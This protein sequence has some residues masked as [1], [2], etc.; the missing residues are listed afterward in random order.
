VA[1][2]RSTLKLCVVG[3]GW[4]GLAAAV[5]AAVAGHAVTLFEMAPQLGGRARRVPTAPQDPAG[6]A[7]DNGQHILIGA[8][9]ESLRLMRQVGVDVQAAFDRRPLTLQFA[10]GTGLHLPAGPALTAFARG[11]LAARGWSLGDRL[12]LLAAAGSWLLRGFRC[13]PSLSVAQLTAR[14]P[15]RLREELLAPLCVA[16]LNTPVERASA[17][18]F[19]RVMHDALFAGPGAADL[20]LPRVDLSA[21]WPE[22]A[23]D[24]LHAQGTR[25]E[26]GVRVAALE[27]RPGG[28][29]VEGE[30]FDRVILACSAVEAARLAQQEAP[31]WAE[32]A[33]AL[34][35]EPIVTVLVSSA[36]TRLA[37]P[38]LALR[39]GL[40]QYAFDLGQLRA[41]AAAAGVL[42]AVISGAREAVEQG[43]E[44][45]AESV[46]QQLTRELGPQLHQEPKVLRTLC[47]K[48]ATFLCTPDLRRPP[49]AIAAGLWAA[50][51]YVEGPYPATL[52]GAVRSGSAAAR[53]S[54]QPH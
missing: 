54:T 20:L 49:A 48:R 5:E 27:R 38:M 33:R 30:A 12:A 19:L 52:E 18:V 36:G 16:A 53:R 46:R 6:L 50:G 45:A 25:I 40:A 1:T 41:D 7:F 47:E 2:G 14:L 31:A 13:A 28:W 29:A 10:D 21:L 37:Q 42:A 39:Q 8:Y 34:R 15:Q 24:W 44:V 32:Q 17:A 43:L 35:Y 3:G 11:V 9:G 22:K 4:A 23:R 26:T 51:D